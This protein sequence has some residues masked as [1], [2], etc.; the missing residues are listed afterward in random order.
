MDESTLQ[1]LKYPIGTFII[2]EEIRESH[3]K[4]WIGDLEVLPSVLSELVL[5]LDDE[6]LSEPYR[7]EGWTIRQL[8]HHISDSHHN[9]YIRF[10]WALTEDT[11]RIKVYEQEKWAELHD[12]RSAPISM[13]LD[14]LKVV[15][16]KLVF[17]LKGLKDQ[18]LKKGF[19][20][21]ETN[22]FT[23]LEENIGR[24]AWHGNHHTQHIRNILQK[25]GW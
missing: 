14:H 6:Q 9:S 25:K 7:P 21:P 8:I 22:T 17:L 15:H 12:S 5:S 18:D 1:N 3:L 4:K 24:Y 13:S 23:S 10:K 20:H 11:P 19:I 16:A 2:P